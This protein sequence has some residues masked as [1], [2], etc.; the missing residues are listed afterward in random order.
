M[1]AR[2]R[3]VIIFQMVSPPQ[4]PPKICPRCHAVNS[5]GTPFCVSCGLAL[6]TEQQPTP[7]PAPV[8]MP[9][10]MYQGPPVPYVPAPPLQS[11][12]PVQ[13]RYVSVVEALRP[14]KPATAVFWAGMVGLV[15]SCLCSAATGLL[16]VVSQLGSADAGEAD[17]V[18]P[19]LYLTSAI[20]FVVFVGASVL[21]LALGRPRRGAG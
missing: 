9:I 6:M 12:G 18:A 20:I 13:P 17:T 7:P 5:P 8:P 19:V 3:S 14:S 15:L 4:L 2:E 11:P 10:R 16:G 21:L 1:R